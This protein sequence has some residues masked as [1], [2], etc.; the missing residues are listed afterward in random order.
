VLALAPRA[1][2]A[3]E[4]LYTQAERFVDLVAL[5]ERQLD[6]GAIGDGAAN[7]R[8]KIARVAH[9]KLNDT[10]RA[11]DE[12]GESLGADADHVGAQNHPPCPLV[13]L[14]YR[15]RPPTEHTGCSRFDFGMREPPMSQQP[16]ISYSGPG[17]P[18]RVRQAFRPVVCRTS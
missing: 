12:L 9:G 13:V 17:R 11:L 14:S 5:H 2:D 15:S 18:L 6:D 16:S 1:V 8:V 7:I 3:L 10:A 4:Q